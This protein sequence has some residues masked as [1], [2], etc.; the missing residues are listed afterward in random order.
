MQI[1]SAAE[2]ILLHSYDYN[3]DIDPLGLEPSTERVDFKENSLN[4]DND[5]EQLSRDFSEGIYE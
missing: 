3:T 5:L 1:K 2:R 4:E